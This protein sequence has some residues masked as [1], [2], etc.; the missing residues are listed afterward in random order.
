MSAW[1]AWRYI[2]SPI[3]FCGVQCARDSELMTPGHALLGEVG[4]EKWHKVEVEGGGAREDDLI[5]IGGHGQEWVVQ[6]HQMSH[7]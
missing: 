6:R 7:K 2:V 3:D 1:G 5:R 4:A